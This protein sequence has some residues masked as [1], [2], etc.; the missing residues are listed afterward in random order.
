VSSEYVSARGPRPTRNCDARCRNENIAAITTFSSFELRIEMIPPRRHR[1]ENTT[2]R[3]DARLAALHAGNKVN[4]LGSSPSR[5]LRGLTDS[6]HD[7]VST[8]W[9]HPSS[10]IIGDSR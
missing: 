9:S 5:V 7:R 2:A 6:G 4:F 1:L 8:G 10:V 3:R